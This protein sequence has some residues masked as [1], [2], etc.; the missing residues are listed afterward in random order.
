MRH[1]FSTEFK[2]ANASTGEVSGYGAIFNNVDFGSDR[3]EAG[4]FRKSIAC[5]DKLPMLHEHRDTVGVWTSMREDARGLAVSGRI[6]DTQSGRDVRTLA[7]DGAVSG[8]SIGYQPKAHRYEGEIRVLES[9]DLLEVSLV[10]FP[11]NQFAKITAA[12]SLLARGEIPNFGELERL[13]CSAG[14]S[15]RQ[16]KRLLIDGYSGMSPTCAAASLIEH[17]AHRLEI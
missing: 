9:V 10:T 16:A 15:R 7:K 1:A 12:K 6:S 2:L 14:L 13:L 11:M 8:L 17:M 5:R 3:I 4:A